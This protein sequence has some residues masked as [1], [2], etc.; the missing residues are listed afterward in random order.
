MMIMMINMKSKSRTE[1]EMVVTE[2]RK[3]FG[4]VNCVKCNWSWYPRMLNPVSCPGCKTYRW[5]EA[6]ES[7]V[8]S[9]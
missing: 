3:R 5:K 8:K 6:K 4:E 7:K 2:L 1:I 9:R